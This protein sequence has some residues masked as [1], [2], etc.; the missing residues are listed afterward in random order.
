MEHVAFKQLAQ[1]SMPL[2]LG[3]TVPNF[4]ADTTIGKIKFHDFIGD[5]WA[6]LFSHPSD[7]TPVC[8]TELGQV[9]K[10]IPEFQ[11]RGVKVSYLFICCKSARLLITFCIITSSFSVM[12]LIK[13]FVCD[14]VIA[15]S[16]D[17]VQDHL[18]WIED[19]KGYNG[20]SSFDYPIIADPTR[21]LANQFGMIDAKLGMSGMPVTCR[22]VFIFGPDK[23]MKLQILYPASTGRNFAEVYYVS[24]AF[25]RQLQHAFY[26]FVLFAC[27]VETYSGADFARG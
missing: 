5:S 25:A 20:L 14:Q 9:Q 13:R 1:Q 23:K 27:V 17:S 2:N 3:E 16:C 6:I 4:E 21:E 15:L 26:S 12:K 8:T 10:L 24:V 19:V 18:G 22:A 7:Y 11:A